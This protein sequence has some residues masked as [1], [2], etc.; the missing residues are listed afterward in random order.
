MRLPINVPN[1]AHRDFLPRLSKKLKKETR[2]LTLAEMHEILGLP[3][4]N[5]VLAVQDRAILTFLAGMGARISSACAL[6]VSNFR[7]DKEN[8]PQVR[9]WEKGDK[10]RWEGCHVKVALALKQHIQKAELTSGPMFRA[11]LNARS[12]KLG[13]R[14][15]SLV[16]M[17]RVVQRYLDELP[18]G[19]V[20][21]RR[22]DGSEELASVFHPH[23]IRA[24][25]ATVLHEA[26][27]HPDKIQRLLGHKKPETTHCYNKQKLKPRDSASHAMP[28]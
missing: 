11:R 7:E 28:L 20:L 5:D 12:K 18:G 14:R 22:Q 19:Q 27:V 8:G 24:T 13:N 1:P 23:C 25:T 6:D 2:D 15:M 26:G 3:K 16:S 4:G 9:L 21:E 17:Y 10:E